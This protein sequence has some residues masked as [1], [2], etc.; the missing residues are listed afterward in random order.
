MTNNEFLIN[1]LT[2]LINELEVMNTT[3]KQADNPN[4]PQEVDIMNFVPV[5]AI[6]FKLPTSETLVLLQHLYDM[7]PGACISLFAKEIAIFLDLRYPDH[8]SKLDEY[9]VL[10]LTDGCI[11]PCNTPIKNHQCLALFRTLDDAK[12]ACKVLKPMLKA[13]YGKQ[14]NKKH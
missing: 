10:S 9:F 12:F 4:H 14:K 7:N 8:I 6:K 1:F 13:V 11:H 2:K 5:L 3:P